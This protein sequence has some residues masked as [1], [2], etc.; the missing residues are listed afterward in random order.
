MREIKNI[1]DT[2]YR[3]TMSHQEVTADFLASYLPATVREQIK[4]DA[5]AIPRTPLSKRDGLI[6]TRPTW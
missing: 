3:E 2:F 6:Q 4:L 5:P 1:R